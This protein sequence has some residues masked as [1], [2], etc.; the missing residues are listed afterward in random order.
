MRI[1]RLLV[2]LILA[3]AVSTQAQTIVERR[4]ALKVAGNKVVDQ[5][6]EPIQL[7]GM[8]FFWSQ[9]MTGFYNRDVVRWLVKDWQCPLVRAAMGV[10]VGGG[11]LSNPTGAVAPITKVVD[12][13]IAN[14]I[15]VI[16]D[17]HEEMAIDHVEESKVFFGEMAKK[18]GKYPNVIFELYNEPH[19]SN[20]DLN[21]TWEQ[22]KSYSEQVI[23]VIREHSNNLVIVGTPN[24]SQ[25]VDEASYDPI[26]PT[27]YGAVAYTL[28]FYAGTHGASL[29]NKG[30]TA[31]NNGVPLF[32]TEWGTT[33]ADGGQLTGPSKGKV[34]PTE[35][36]A[37]FT[38]MDQKKISSCNWSIS[39]KAEGASILVP[40]ASTSGGWDPNTDLT[41]SGRYIRTKI[42]EH[43]AAD[44]NVCPYLGP[45]PATFPVPGA[46]DPSQI[47]TGVGLSSEVSQESSSIK[48]LIS[49][50]SGDWATYSIN[51]SAP[52]TLIVRAKVQAIGALDS[53]TLRANGKDVSIPVGGTGMDG[54]YWAYGNNRLTVPAGSSEI[55]IR[56]Q[57][58][59]T[60]QMKIQA[61][62]LISAPYR[63]HAAPTGIP[64]ELF[65]N[66]GASGVEV[67]AK[68]DGSLPFLANFKN[69][70]SISYQ[71]NFNVS[72][73]QILNLE[74]ASGSTGGKLFLRATGSSVRRDT[75]E[76]S[77]TGG[78]FSWKPE[79]FSFLVAKG[80]V[81]V[82]L[83]AAGD[84]GSLFN[85]SGLHTWDA[86]SISSRMASN[87]LSV[88]RT[89]SH[90]DLDGLDGAG[91]RE[92]MVVS[93]EGRI[94]S[95]TDISGLP[96]AKIPLPSSR[97]PVWIRL[98]G[99]T[100]AT[101]S[102]PPTR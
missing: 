88:V 39:D 21:P 36:N 50:D 102:V 15:Y 76:V 64:I 90:L 4:G 1:V 17:W 71:A 48:N 49:I 18:Y 93:A 13:A 9:W 54:W 66:T 37:W 74:V 67:V 56:F 31:M 80:L 41:E 82:N 38:W 34:Y 35:S 57:A 12:A 22:I 89:R 20:P 92:A 28:H 16:I 46:I 94:L 100:S 25:D 63:P 73:T 62:E 96:S 52:E 6:G 99:I 61:I 60:N 33:T 77:P 40:G 86:T 59:G 53:I 47:S 8:S 98:N 7:T 83:S 97:L 26:D 85:V 69:G 68:T 32:V 3:G 65:S 42:Q 101:L 23:P 5:N 87:A 72:G 29:R 79:S 43:C 10:T 91:F 27:I 30:N 14:G 78:W 58:P 2:A 45:E 19:N 70:A 44:P 75:I 95:R 24:Y 51:A 84:T 81:V 55:E 11:Y